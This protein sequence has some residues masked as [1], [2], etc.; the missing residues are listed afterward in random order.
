MDA[1][2]TSTEATEGGSEATSPSPKGPKARF[3]VEE[4][5]VTPQKEKDVLASETAQGRVEAPSDPAAAGKGDG[6]LEGAKR[7][8]V[9][10]VPTT[11]SSADAPAPSTAVVAETPVAPLLAETARE[12]SATPEM[13]PEAAAATATV[14]SAEAGE[15]PAAKG[16]TTEQ[17]RKERAR[18]AFADASG[19]STP[20]TKRKAKVDT[21]EP[22]AAF[23]IGEHPELSHM[24]TIMRGGAAP[25]KSLFVQSI[26]IVE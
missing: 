16:G 10:E 22:P 25:R 23:D 6:A 13:P 26:M 5:P 24:H 18:V 2:P 14:A 12:P 15:V 17:Q 21:G 8:A 19:S 11:E 1:A 9:E 20:Q 7:F 4:V 3:V